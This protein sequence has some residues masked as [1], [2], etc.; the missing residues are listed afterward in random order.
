MKHTRADSDPQAKPAARRIPLQR[1]IELRFPHFQGLVTGMSSNL[2]TRGMFIQSEHPKRAGTL[3]T[4]QFRIEDWSPI[5]GTARVVWSRPRAEGPDRPAGMGVEFVDLDAQSRR[6]I[7]WLVER[8]VQAGGQ[9]FNIRGAPSRV[10]KILD[11]LADMDAPT[12]TRGVSP[13]R[14]EPKGP[15]RARDQG[16]KAPGGAATSRRRAVMIATVVLVAALSAYS[17]WVDSRAGSRHLHRGGSETKARV[18]APA[19]TPE[20]GRSDRAPPSLSPAPRLPAE[21]VDVWIQRWASAWES[22][23]VDQVLVLYS[24][25]FRPEGG[26]SRQQWETRIERTMNEAEFLRVSISALEISLTD[27]ENATASF[28]RTFRSN[29]S[30]E[31]GRVILELEVTGDGW[32]ILR[33]RV[34]S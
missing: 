12:A 13:V 3:F 17:F 1:L 5:Q 31:T 24:P 4:F 6:M 23:D 8:H 18:D 2:S 32:R 20:S 26:L 21:S 16:S 15:P 33:E 9:P 10:S 25:D 14:S 30:T 19:A 29:T 28:Y 7:A 34:S 22:L 27:S 11:E